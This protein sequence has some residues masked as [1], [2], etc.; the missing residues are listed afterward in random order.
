MD[1]LLGHRPLS[2]VLCYGVDIGFEEDR[3]RTPVDQSTS[4]TEGS[5]TDESSIDAAENSPEKIPTETGDSSHL[6]GD[7][8]HLT[9]DSSHPTGD[10]SHQT[11][12]SSHL[13]TETTKK[14][15]RPS[16]PGYAKALSV[17]STEQQAFLETMQESQNRQLSVQQERRMQ[18]EERLLSR[19]IE[20][21]SRSNEQLTGHL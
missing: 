12:D 6:T 1:D 18:S 8:S 10:S 13:S 16:S 19:F 2:N 14:R 20:E 5:I 17:W 7:S 11:G 4:A 9:G 15:K 3:F 21:S